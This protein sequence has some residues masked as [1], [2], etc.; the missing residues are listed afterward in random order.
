MVVVNSVLNSSYTRDF[1]FALSSASVN[2]GLA[3][4]FKHNQ[5][6]FGFSPIFYTYDKTIR[7]KFDIGYNYFF[8]KR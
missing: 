1:K 8:M 7:P 6:N 3:V 4:R 5:L 2:L